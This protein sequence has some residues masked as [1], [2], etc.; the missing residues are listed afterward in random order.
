MDPVGIVTDH[1]HF[2]RILWGQRQSSAFIFQQNYRFPGCLQHTLP[3]LRRVV[4]S[5]F[6]FFSVQHMQPQHH[7]QNISHLFINQRF[8]NF[9]PFHRLFQRGCQTVFIKIICHGHFYIQTALC[10][11]FCMMH[12]TPVR[13]Y[14]AVIFPFSPQ[15]PVH[16]Y[17]ALTAVLPL[18]AV[19]GPHQRIGI[20]LF[21]RFFKGG[22]VDL[23]Q[24]PVADLHL[25]IQALCLLIIYG[26]MLDAGCHIGFLNALNQ[27]YRQFSRQIRILTHIFKV[28]SAEG[29]SFDID[30]RC[31][32]H[33]L[34]PA[35]GLLPQYPAR[36][37]GNLPVP[38]GG[39]GTV[40]GQIGYIVIAV[41]DC[42]PC[43]IFKLMPYSHGTVRHFHCRDPQPF[44]RFC[45]E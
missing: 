27:R 6:P 16:Q 39:K 25:H 23:S 13:Y 29:T 19:V 17:S 21:H 5:G 40:A 3:V 22:K 36:L 45:P 35:S 10:R 43:I 41:S 44:H 31:Q 26:K 15:D 18:I 20:S 4:A 42:L 33:I 14:H 8:G 7:S 12:R 24:R 30:P 28:S 11:L 38:G 2:P 9:S 32:D 1:Q 37:T 34:A